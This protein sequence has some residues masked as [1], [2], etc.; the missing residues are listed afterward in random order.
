MF[1]QH[2]LRVCVQD[3]PFL[4]DEQT[5]GHGQETAKGL[6]W[7]ASLSLRGNLA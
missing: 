5:A 4:V 3:A 1:L 2:H 7:N 6:F